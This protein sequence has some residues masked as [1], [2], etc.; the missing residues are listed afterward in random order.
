MDVLTGPN[1]TDG[2]KPVFSD[3]PI[4]ELTAAQEM[5]PILA[6]PHPPDQQVEAEEPQR[7]PKT[8]PA[9]QRQRGEFDYDNPDSDYYVVPGDSRG[10][11]R[12]VTKAYFD[13]QP[14]SQGRV[15]ARY[16]QLVARDSQTFPVEP[17]STV[18]IACA[19]H[20]ETA[21]MLR[22][23]LA[24]AAAQKGVQE[25][26]IVLYGNMPDTLSYDEKIATRAMFDQLIVESRSAHPHLKIRSVIEEY[27]PSE[28]LSDPL[29]LHMGR[30]RHDIIDLVAWDA[31]Q[32]GGFKIDHPI[33]VLDA[34]T[35]QMTKDTFQKLAARLTAPDSDAL[36]VH[37]KT[38]YL[39]DTKSGFD[40]EGHMSDV[41][42][43]A[44]L[45]E[46]RRRQ[47]MRLYNKNK[48][49]YGASPE[50]A[51]REDYIEEWGSAMPLGALLM[52]G[53]YNEFEPVSE[54]TYLKS[55]LFDG[56]G[57]MRAVFY[58]VKPQI[59]S[60]WM[61]DTPYYLLDTTI[62]T[63]GRR[64]EDALRQWILGG[65]DEELHQIAIRQLGGRSYGGFSHTEPLRSANT[66]PDPHFQDAAQAEQIVTAALGRDSVQ[67]N[68][69]II[70]LPN[71]EP[72]MRRLNLP[73]PSV[74]QA[75]PPDNDADQP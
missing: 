5:T 45:Q 15:A 38:Q 29:A 6:E 69:K 57:V 51:Y 56:D 17:R 67:P 13:A 18:V 68:Q 65:P 55:R 37:T 19:V 39:F 44:I 54:N 71:P 70:S 66:K 16:K 22:E 24:E 40:E 52:A 30:I 58:Y 47:R 62:R 4:T 46:I 59:T 8:S 34:D 27:K 32:R 11:L 74:E 1:H 53:N 61:R 23:T 75:K 60:R 49:L 3:K 31:Q 14:E 26:E 33:I 7:R 48:E 36:I 72:L 12:A 25:D 28:D 73:L 21:D 43:T 50:E 9:S 42:K 41:R 10:M 64:Q 2:D 35:K 20:N 63:S